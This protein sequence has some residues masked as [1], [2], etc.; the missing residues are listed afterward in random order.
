MALPPGKRSRYTL[1][2]GLG[3]PKSRFGRFGGKEISFGSRNLV[4]CCFERKKK[5]FS[6]FNQWALEQSANRSIDR[7]MYEYN[8]SFG[9]SD[10]GIV[11]SNPGL[12]INV[13]SPLLRCPVR[14][15]AL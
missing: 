15:K 3:G 4:G 10:S 14:T 6:H 5:F 11:G 7:L 13:Y 1:N 12:N 9:R 2:S 8:T